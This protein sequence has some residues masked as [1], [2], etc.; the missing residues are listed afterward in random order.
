[1]QTGPLSVIAHWTDAAFVLLVPDEPAVSAEIWTK[2]WR[3]GDEEQAAALER[4][5]HDWLAGTDRPAT[6]SVH[7][8]RVATAAVEG[9]ALLAARPLDAGWSEGELKL[10]DFAGQLLTADGLGP[11]PGDVDA[12]LA[13][14]LREALR[15][16]Q[17]LVLYQPEVDLWSRR[18]IAAEALVRW[19]H[20]TLGLLDPSAFIPVAEQ[21]ELIQ[22]VGTWVLRAALD[23]LAHWSKLPAGEELMLRVNVSPAQ[24]S[25]GGVVGLIAEELRERQLAGGRVCVEITESVLPPDF[26]HLSDT[27]EQ[28]RALGVSTAIDDWGTGFSRLQQLRLLRV[29]TV[30]LDRS[31]VS[32]VDTDERAAAI[33]RALV[34]LARSLDLVV[35]AEGVETEGEASTLLSLGCTR[36]QGHLFGPALAAEQFEQLLAD[37]TAE[38]VR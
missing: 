11:T 12:H 10:L 7:G 22:E 6:A 8:W 21:S 18:V 37:G 33:I 25:R 13:A 20:P 27:I 3:A 1:V 16:G 26:A 29:D 17:L 2:R 28:L 5:A 32:G 23:Q 35:I 34:G 38:P 14:D 31:Y 9:G 36:A 4:F 15:E 19:E 30:K 24:I